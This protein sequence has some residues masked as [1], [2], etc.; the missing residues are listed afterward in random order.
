MVFHHQVLYEKPFF[1]LRVE[2]AQRK[3]GKSGA[4]EG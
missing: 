4:L 1:Y 2:C 3:A